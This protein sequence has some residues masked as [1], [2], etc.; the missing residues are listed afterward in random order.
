MEEKKELTEEELNKLDKTN[1]VWIDGLPCISCDPEP[2]K[3][4][5]HVKMVE[6]PNGK[7]PF[8]ILFDEIK[9]FFM[10]GFSD[11]DKERERK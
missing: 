8:D 6:V 9:K 1:I 2:P 3:S 4:N 11:A 10:G 7:D 5:I